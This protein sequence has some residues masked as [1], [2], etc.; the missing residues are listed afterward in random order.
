MPGA[1]DNERPYVYTNPHPN[2]VVL[3]T[4]KVL[5][6]SPISKELTR[7]TTQEKQESHH[8]KRKHKDKD[9]EKEEDME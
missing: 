3:K 8:H 9:T 6:L 1:T 7:Q 4:D 5:L 2:T